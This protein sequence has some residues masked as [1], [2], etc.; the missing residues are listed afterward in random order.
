MKREIFIKN[1][2]FKYLSE[3]FENLFFS[4]NTL[5]DV[6]SRAGKIMVSLTFDDVLDE[7]KFRINKF[8]RILKN[9][10]LEVMLYD[11]IGIFEGIETNAISK[12]FCNRLKRTINLKAFF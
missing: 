1:P 7:Y 12:Y 4:F 2:I 6:R 9:Q 5:M 10:S 3:Y 11:L 8:L